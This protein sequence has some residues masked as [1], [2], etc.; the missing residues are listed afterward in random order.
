MYR[1]A[2]CDDNLQDGIT[3]ASLTEAF[4]RDLGEEFSLSRFHSMGDLLSHPPFDLYV[5]DV[6]MP[7]MSGIEGAARLRSLP[8]DDLVVVFITSSLDSAVDGYRVNASGFILKPVDPV[9]FR[10][11]MDRVYR[12][13]LLPR[14]RVLTLSLSRTPVRIPFGQIRFV[15]SRLHRVEIHLVSRDVSALMKLSELEEQLLL[16]PGFIRCH[17]SYLV[18]LRHVEDLRPEGFLLRDGGCVPISRAY[19][20]QCKYSFYRFALGAAETEGLRHE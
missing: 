5:L 10:E 7:G 20:K 3:A 16:D 13:R 12:Q 6:L 15:E 17:Q 9:K 11:T 4:F 14:G 1:I 19:L 18:N 8:G 2:V